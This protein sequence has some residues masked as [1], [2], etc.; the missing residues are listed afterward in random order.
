MP[1]Q[2][3]FQQPPRPRPQPSGRHQRPWSAHPVRRPL[4]PVSPLSG[5]DDL[6]TSLRGHISRHPLT[7]L[8]LALLGGVFLG[9]R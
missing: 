8:S 2:Q 6:T 9:R 3:T 5:L 4:Y 7:A 1:R